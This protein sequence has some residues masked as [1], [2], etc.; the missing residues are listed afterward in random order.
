M[1]GPVVLHLLGQIR[2]HLLYNL[3]AHVVQLRKWKIR[4]RFILISD[5][6]IVYDILRR[7]LDT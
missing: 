7:N 1:V 4:N 2:L 5:F 6:N 3:P